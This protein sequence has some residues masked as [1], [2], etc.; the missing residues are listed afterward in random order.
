[1]RKAEHRLHRAQK[2]EQAFLLRQQKKK[3]KHRGR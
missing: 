3:E 2:A 1:M